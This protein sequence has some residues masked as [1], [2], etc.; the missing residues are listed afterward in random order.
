LAEAAQEEVASSDDSA[1]PSLHTDMLLQLYRETKVTLQNL[2]PNDVALRVIAASLNERVAATYTVDDV[3]ARLSELAEATRLPKLPNDVPFKPRDHI[4][5]TG[6]RYDR[7]V[8]RYRGRRP[9]ASQR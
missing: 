6:K 8:T 9:A 2:L 7:R 4:K 1:W 5:T 3:R